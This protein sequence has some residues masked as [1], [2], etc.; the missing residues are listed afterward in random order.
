MATGE[1]TASSSSS[2]ASAHAD[3]SVRVAVRVR[4]LSTNEC[5]QACESC[6]TAV[7]DA[8]L[9]GGKAGKRYD[10][11]AVFDAS[12]SQAPLFD[13]LVQPLIERFFD[14]YNATVFAY[15]QTGMKQ[16]R[17]ALRYPWGK[18]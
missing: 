18:R 7:G 13:G 9:V 10:F 16:K 3:S 4:P 8:V 2:S 5:A 14:G 17:N 11:D 12:M 1:L 15:G 6:V